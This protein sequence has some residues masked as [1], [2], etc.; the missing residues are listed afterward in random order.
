[1]YRWPRDPEMSERG[2]AA[3]VNCLA[4]MVPPVIK[5]EPENFRDAEIGKSELNEWARRQQEIIDE[6]TEKR[7]LF[8]LLAMQK[9]VGGGMHGALDAYAEYLRKEY[10]D[11]S[12][13]NTVQLGLTKTQP[14]ARMG[15]F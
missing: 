9:P 4:L 6:A 3:L 15:M 12:S 2:Y 14:P 13:P 1:V 8:D 7:N 10:F 5:I 11:S